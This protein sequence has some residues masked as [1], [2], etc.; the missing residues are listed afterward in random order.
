MPA[1]KTSRDRWRRYWDR[2]PVSYDKQMRFFDRTVFK[3]SR[4]WVCTRASGDTLEIAGE[5][6]P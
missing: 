6:T 1:E 4:Q 2:Q 5:H 3:D